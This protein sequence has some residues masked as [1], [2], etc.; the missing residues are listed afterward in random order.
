VNGA[1][2]MGGMHGFGRVEIEPSE[3]VFHAPWEGRMFALNR[4]IAHFR[5]WNLDIVRH[6]VE[7]IPPAQYLAAGYYERWLLA[8]E[9][10]LIEHGFVTPIELES[11]RAE[12][13]VEVVPLRAAEI[14]T[15][16]KWRGTERMDVDVA[17]RFKIGDRVVTRMQNSTEH[18][19]LP[20]YARGRAGVIARDHGVYSFPDTNAMTRDKKPQHCYNV[21][22]SARE[23]WGPVAA[24]RDSVH[25]DLWDDH[26]DAA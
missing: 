1:H 4:A 5:R 23:L 19:R 11:G 24:E 15:A 10:R 8:F 22:F 25:I 13:R 6:S 7:R 2:D 14:P 20:R 21:R 12:G 16:L 26:L 18:T 9:S 3:P 17:P